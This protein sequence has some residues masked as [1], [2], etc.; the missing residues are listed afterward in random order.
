MFRFFLSIFYTEAFKCRWHS[1]NACKPFVL[2]CNFKIRLK[3]LTCSF[4]DLLGPFHISVLQPTTV[5]MMSFLGALWV[6]FMELNLPFSK[7]Q[8]EANRTRA[9][10]V[11][12]TGG[13]GQNFPLAGSRSALTALCASHLRGMTAD[14]G[15]LHNFM[16]QECADR[17]LF[18]NRPLPVS[19]LVS[20]IRNKTQIPA[21]QCGQRPYGTRLYIVGYNH[22]DPPL[23]KHI[24]L[25]V[26]LTAELVSVKR[27]STR[28]QNKE[29]IK[30]LLGNTH[31]Q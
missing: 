12:M 23:P 19:P 20:L 4:V 16:F 27:E 3:S 22:M 9:A 24:H 5:S 7:V 29:G 8:L 17:T 13:R 15:L 14:A 6:G 10:L 25:P 21:Q 30:Y 26:I 1:T 31:G 11:I 18:S 2:R 28:A